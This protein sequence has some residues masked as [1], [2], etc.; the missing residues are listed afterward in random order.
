MPNELMEIW[1]DLNDLIGAQGGVTGR[2]SADLTSNAAGENFYAVE[3]VVRNM[4]LDFEM[5][6]NLV[7]SLTATAMSDAKSVTETDL[8]A[9]LEGIAMFTF[10]IGW[11]HGR[12]LK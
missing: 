4:G 10:L 9:I 8:E 2:E 12:S 7:R 5:V 11:R 1:K 6:L 3:I